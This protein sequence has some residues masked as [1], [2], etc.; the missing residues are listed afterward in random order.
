MSALS[1]FR[2]VCLGLT[3]ALVSKW[4][5]LTAPSSAAMILA[6][7]TPGNVNRRSSARLIGRTLPAIAECDE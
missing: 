3:S 7:K 5:S 2:T 6:D 1:T 4:I